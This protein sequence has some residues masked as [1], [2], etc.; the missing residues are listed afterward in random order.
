M[1]VF[2]YNCIF[3]NNS[4]LIMS[5]VQS[6]KTLE[7]SFEMNRTPLSLSEGY[8]KVAGW[9]DVMGAKVVVSTLTG[10]GRVA[11]GTLTTV[12]SAIAW[13]VF[14]LFKSLHSD[15]ARRVFCMGIEHMCVGVSEF[16][17]LK[18]LLQKEFVR[19]DINITL[20]DTAAPLDA[21]RGFYGCMPTLGQQFYRACRGNQVKWTVTERAGEP[22]PP[23]DPPTYFQALDCPIVVS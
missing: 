1:F 13:G 8:V 20:M 10:A 15:K 4:V 6:K 12:I 16:F 9:F 11:L 7:P 21:G 14:A 19:R 2:C 23:Y 18:T 5:S 17:S 22:P 3:V